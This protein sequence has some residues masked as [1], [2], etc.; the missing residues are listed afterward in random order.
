MG[1]TNF[2]QSRDMRKRFLEYFQSKDHTVVPSG[3]TVPHDDPTLLFTNAGM[4]QFKD[5]FLGKTKRDYTRATSSQKCIRVGGKH[6]DLDNVGHTARHMTFFEMLG[7]FS[8]GD[9]F[10]KEAIAMAFEVTTEIFNYPI[11][12]LWVSVFET[13]DEAF[14]LWKQ[15]L[16]EARI[17]RMG[18]EENFWSMGDTGPCGPCSELLFD[19]GAAF[20]SGTSP[21]DDPTG[22]RYPEFWNLVFM[23]SNRN[24]KGQ[25][26]PLKA[27]SID[28]GAG[29]ERVLMFGQGLHSV[30]ETDVLRSVIG[31]VEQISGK[32]YNPLDTHLAPAFH[33]VADHL[34]SLSFA[35][36]DGAQPS[37]I[38]RGYV[39]R[40]ILRRAVRYARLLG[41]DKPFMAQLTPTLIQLMGPDF[42]ELESAKDR[43]MEILTLEEESFLRT[44]HR[45]GN[46][47]N[48]IIESAGKANH[49]ISGA[50]AFKLKD[51]YGFPIEEILLLAK[52]NELTVNLDTY[53]LLEKEA[54]ERSKQAHKKVAQEAE[55]GLYVE[56]VEKHGTSEFV[57]FD[58]LEAEGTV[59]GLIRNG[60][61][62]DKLEAGDE[63]IVILSQT[64]FYAEKGGQ[65]GDIGVLD[66]KGAHFK[67]T[68]CVEPYPGVIAHIGTLTEGALIASEPVTANV[69]PAHR[70]YTACHHTATHLLQWALLEV[71]G[72][73]IRQAGS[74]VT[75]DRLR[76]DFNH[77]KALS[78]EEIRHIEELVNA[79]IRENTTLET[80]ELKYADLQKRADIKQFFGD[81]YGSVVRVVDIG[82]YSKELCGGTHVHTLSEI[83]LFRIAKESSIAAGVRRIEALT[84]LEAEKFMYMADNQLG[85]LAK[86]LK[87]P[88]A[89]LQ[90]AVDSMICEN[91]ALKAELKI[92][93]TQALKTLASE[94]VQAIETIEGIPAI[95]A[96]VDIPASELQELASN[97]MDR[98]Q[99]GVICLGTKA[100]GKGQLL[101]RV[102]P[103]FVE[104]GLKAGAFIKQLAPIIGGGGGG[105][106]DSAQAGGKLP[107]ELPKA[108]EVFR[109]LLSCS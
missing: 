75:P 97:L 38:E 104:K 40:K 43:I 27:Q 8:F 54:R 2:M 79:K 107:E 34:R 67:V 52:D 99:S 4:N 94:L 10:K 61:F 44:L 39:L 106:P 66:H 102:S 92:Y 33:V 100:D 3:P 51:T 23:Q 32:K 64:P 20:G 12:K 71:L 30:F 36:A 37:N 109:S 31:V 5:V 22:E 88:S 19:R 9:Y 17:V 70:K 90:E 91:A 29:L 46:I 47:L 16:P 11:E 58:A 76:F 57:G 25:E 78:S 81:K 72:P 49:Q 50:D 26:V 108:F 105:K 28:T 65:V 24:A 14:E 77:H 1:Y 80:Y 73:H 18:V 68:G 85:Q 62:V 53:E 63:G 59:L 45:G 13:D 21:L 15:Y 98:L 86:H 48:T 83:G 95:I 35:I 55:E 96:S 74:L 7:N 82:G 103:D 93:K 60:Q 6:N 89:K 84:G 56:F 87:V 69:E 41:L 101:I 42:P